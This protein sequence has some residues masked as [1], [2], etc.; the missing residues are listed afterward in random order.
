MTTGPTR[1]DAPSGGA[2][3][4]GMSTGPGAGGGVRSWRD[5]SAGFGW[6][7]AGV[8]VVLGLVPLT[9]MGP[10]TDLDV[11]A[12]IQSGRAVLDGDY[13]VSRAPGA[14]VH[15]AAVGGLEAIG[16]TVGPNLGSLAA[17]VA[18]TVLLAVL[19]RREGVGRVGLS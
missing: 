3:D 4:V 7:V 12:V 1:A 19:L 17:G 18:L 9:L 2:G 14:P 15:E 8:L 5:V 11:A 6:V 16:G 13:A 10:G